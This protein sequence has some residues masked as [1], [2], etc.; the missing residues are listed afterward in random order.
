MSERRFQIVLIEDAEPDVFLVREALTL[1]KLKFELQVLG[2]GEKAVE[3]I[4]ALESA[5]TSDRP[6]LFLLDLNLPRVN[7]QQVLARMRQS[8]SCAQIPVLIVTSSDSP[9]DK[10]QSVRLGA[11]RYFRKPSQLDDFMKL[12]PLVR[13]LLE[14]AGPGSAI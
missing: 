4:G 3:F 9:Q 7:G 13:E 1:S 14:N 10:A 12:G 2:D 11:T 8:V 6:D 5:P